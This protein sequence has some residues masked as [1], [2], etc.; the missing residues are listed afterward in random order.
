[1]RPKK[2]DAIFLGGGLSSL[3]LIKAMGEHAPGRIAIIDSRDI[4]NPRKV[5]WSYWT[6]ADK[7]SYY[8]SFA[9][10]SWDAAKLGDSP[11][12]SLKPYT[13]R[14][15][16]STDVLQNLRSQLPAY[17]LITGTALAIEAT[18]QGYRVH[19]NDLAITAD[20]LFDSAPDVSPQF[21][22]GSTGSVLSGTGLLV[23]SQHP[24]FNTKHATL[25]DPLTD[26]GFAYVLPLS[27]SSALVESAHF[28][29]VAI[30][31][32]DAAL[33]QYLKM[34]YGNVDFTIAH[35]EYGVI[36]LG[37]AS[38]PSLGP[39][40]IFLGAKRG[41]VKA[42]A[43]YGILAIEQS[44]RQLADLWRRQ[45]PLPSNRTYHQPWEYMDKVFL[46]MLHKDPASAQS[47]MEL[48][49]RHLSLS[50]SLRL[51]DENLPIVKL[52][53]LMT[54]CLPTVGKYIRHSNRKV[55]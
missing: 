17:D 1:M 29:K 47:L 32:D 54:A 41:L 52:S 14:V 3:M 9:I 5:H 6:M 19:L 39:R 43:G 10:A 16:R 11:G 44:S 34:R 49:M 45:Q 46:E 53:R 7:H 4:C 18:S 35:H 50:D 20:W 38:Q 13:L 8:D 51:L 36:P 48:S 24:V 2:Y 40:H 21:P 33:L 37:I 25:F 23:H 42:S 26:G 22:A 15:V 55:Q 27:P 30:A 12:Q 31:R 28:S